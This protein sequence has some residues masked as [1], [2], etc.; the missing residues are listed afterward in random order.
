MARA[1]KAAFLISLLIALAYQFSFVF[2]RTP[3]QPGFLLLLGS[4]PWSWPLTE[5]LVFLNRLLGR[6]VFAI[7]TPIVIGSGFAVNCALACAAV[8]TIRKW[9]KG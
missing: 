1:V 6:Q 3:V 4:L 8:L 2:W 9:W 7:L 5:N